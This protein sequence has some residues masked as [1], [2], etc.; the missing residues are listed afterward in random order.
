LTI[1][2]KVTLPAAILQLA[3]VEL[4]HHAADRL[5][6]AGLVAVGGA[7]DDHARALAE[8]GIVDRFELQDSVRRS[9]SM[10]QRNIGAVILSGNTGD[11]GKRMASSGTPLFA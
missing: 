7:H 4:G 9:C 10:I 1:G 6:A 11:V 8:A 5:G 3:A 2:T